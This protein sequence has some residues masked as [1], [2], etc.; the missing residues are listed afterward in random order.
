ML[1]PKTITVDINIT[2]ILSEVE[3]KAYMIAEKMDDGEIK[4]EVEDIKSEKNKPMLYRSIQRAAATFIDSVYFATRSNS[5]VAKD[6][7]L[8][9]PTSIS[10]VLSLPADYS[11]TSLNALSEYIHDYLVCM[12]LFDF[13]YIFDDKEAQKWN[14]KAQYDISRI[15]HYAS[16]DTPPLRRQPS[17]F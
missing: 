3:V 1:N 12:C 16:E 4:T 17:V 13:L 10:I 15:Q 9:Q 2:A 7:K 6:N 8:S 14:D 5:D 11:Q